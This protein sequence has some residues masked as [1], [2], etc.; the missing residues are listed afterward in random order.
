MK[1]IFTLAAAL[2][3]TAMANA[4]VIAQ[5]GFE[6][7]DS[8]YT[9]EEALTPGGTYGDWVNRKTYDEW[10]EPF[11][12]DK[13][14]GEYSFRA[15]NF[16][17]DGVE[18]YSWDRGF[19]MGN[20]QGIKP[21]TSYRV[22]FWAKADPTFIAADG[23]D[24]ATTITSHLSTGMENFDCSFTSTKGNDYSFDFK[25]FNGD[26][27]H[28]SYVT[29]F[30]SM[31]TQNQVLPNGAYERSWIG[32]S[33]YPG[34]A[35][36]ET[37]LMHF[38]NQFPENMFFVVFNMW[39]AGEY[40][41][42][43]IT[44][45]E[46]TFNAVTFSDDVI[47][48]DFGY[49]T[50]IANLAKAAPDG[51]FHIDPS[52]IKVTRGDEILDVYCLEGHSDG[53]VYAFL[54]DEML[55]PDEEVYVSLATP[56]EIT[57]NTDKR[58]AVYADGDAEMPAVQV[59]DELAYYDETI[60]AI[61]S[62][63]TA[64]EFL[65][66]NPENESFELDAGTFK[67][68]ELRFNKVVDITYASAVL[69][70]SDNFGQYERDLTATMAVNDDMESITI[71]IDK[72]LADGEYKLT[73]SD[74]ASEQG[75]T[76]TNPIVLQ[77]QIGPDYSEGTSEDIFCP[78]FSTVANGT[79][80][81]GWI[82]DD[83]GT[84]HQYILNDDG[85]VGNY[86]WGGNLGGGGARMFGGFTGGDFTKALYWR[87]LNGAGYATLTY[88]EQV[89]DFELSD[90]TY[91]PEMPENI[92]LYLE[93]GKYQ[94]S[95]LMAAWKFEGEV[96]GV[97]PK[98][99]FLLQDV[100]GNETFA[101]FTDVE[102]KPCT[103]G[104]YTLDG[105]ST[106]SVA[107]FTVDSP[108]YYMLKFETHGYKELLL[109]EVKLITMPSK[110]AYWKQQLRAAVEEAQVAYDNAFSEEYDGDTKTALAEKIRHAQETQFHQPSV[111]EAEIADLKA[112]VAALNKR[113]ENI[114]N[115]EVYLLDAQTNME[116]LVGGKYENTPEFI[117]GK[118]LVAKYSEINP[119]T[120]SDA[121][122]NE[123]V[124]ALQSVAAKFSNA[125]N[126]A[127]ILA[128]RATLTAETATSYGIANDN[129]T[130][131]QNA[132]EDLTET[133][134]AVN[135]DIKGKIYAAIAGN[136]N[137][138]PDN[139]CTKIE[140]PADAQAGNPEGVE[141]D[142]ENDC[143]PTA[144]YG[145]DLTSFINNPHLYRVNGNDGVPGWTVAAPKDTTVTTIAYASSPSA[146]N[147]A[148]D[149]EINIYGE[150]NYDFSQV[151]ANLPAGIYTFVMGTRTPFVDKTADY[152]KVFY[153]NAQNDSTGVW[154][155]YI[156]I[157]NGEVTSVAPFIGAGSGSRPDTFA[158]EVKAIDGQ[159]TIGAY[160][161]YVSGKAEKHEDNTPQPFWT[162]T[163][164]AD[165]ARLYLVAPDPD[166]DYAAASTG[167]EGLKD[168]A[169][170]Q[171]GATFNLAGQQVGRDYKGVVIIGGKKMFR[172]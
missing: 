34:G 84:I 136:G 97:Y 51:V 16:N 82:S 113:V 52:L 122:L 128:Y 129:V 50:N 68:V 80:P 110:A 40:L 27:K 7:G 141:Y 10:V 67:T 152:G 103:K 41:L 85:S 118:D 66:A 73:V 92:Q 108:G 29:Y 30:T 96:E 170:V 28:Y 165:N 35:E 137:Q 59:E 23:T 95:F 89:N 155:K 93:P 106:R 32:N 53:F 19:K 123:V 69:S 105:P 65:S 63:W 31:K 62:S 130:I 13:H 45:E 161:H 150:S 135:A 77:Y 120:L 117:E 100:K 158:Q 98:F 133:I 20:L 5:L 39:S 48:F 14:S 171:A 11:N 17:E 168:N 139:L 166:F 64:P 151:V 144:V 56:A 3:F 116:A 91:D 42:D 153:Y 47:K 167:I 33:Q 149:T 104:G 109:A 102:A 37:Y 12:G 101:K 2:C 138:I 83:N 72:A 112:L 60:D 8:K 1:K 18:Y 46:G 36:G 148:V 146:D 79:F 163:T 143:Y 156:Y 21:E 44:I 54:T 15:N 24:Q 147:R 88:G 154:D 172:K 132:V 6:E 25:S 87:S 111:V 9:T 169:A 162:G 61:P 71:T 131:L 43:D 124:P 58:P 126:V 49:P 22:S 86:D 142:E 94:I 76:M 78:D 107:D 4:Q 75:V 38:N 57:Y 81:A 121:E 159:V 55:D 157:T 114:D 134:D 164:M 115:F 160:E 127:N 119:T 125:I 99:D 70:W 26:W 90:G 145:I 140:Y 74:I